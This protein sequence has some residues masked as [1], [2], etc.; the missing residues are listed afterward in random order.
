MSQ[1]VSD[2]AMAEV[3]AETRSDSSSRR[4]G[5]GDDDFVTDLPYMHRVGTPPKQPLFQEIKHSL[6][7]TFFADK[8]F[9]KFKDQSGSRKFVLALQSLFPIL[10]WGRDYNLKKFRGDFV[11]G[12]T[13]ASLCIPQDLAYAK[14][15][16]LDPWY[17]LYSSFVAPLVYAFMGTSRDI[18]IGP[19]AVVSLLLGSLLSS[20]ISD[21]KS[22]DYVR[23]AFTATFFAGVTQLVLGVCRLGFLIDFLSHAAIVGFMAGAAI[24]IALQQLK[25]LLGIKNFTTK[26]DIVSVLHSVWSNVHHGWNWETILI[27][28]SFLIFL[29]ITKYIAKRNKKLFWVSAISPMIS[30]VVSTFFVYITRAD[31]KGVSIVK[32]IKS[33]VNPSSANEIF[34]S[35]KYLGAGVRIGIVSGMVALTEAVAI[36]RTFAAMKDYS[37]DGNKEMVAMGTMNIVGSLTSCYVTTGSFSRSAVNFMAGCQTAVS[38]IVM[39]IVVLLTLLVLTPLF[40]YT[41]NAV[42]ASIIIAAVVNLVNIEAMVLLWKIDKFD[43]VACMGAFFGVIFKSVEIGLLIA[44]AISFAKIL[45]QVTRPRTAVLGKLPGTTVY[46]NIQQYPKAAQIPGM[47][48]IRIDSAIYFS[49]SNYIK[50]RILRWLIEEESQRTESELPGIQNLIVE[51]SPVTDIDTSGI[52]AF[53]ELYKTLQKREVQLILANPGPVVIEKLHASKLTDLIGEDKIFLTVADAVATFGPKDWGRYYTIRN[54]RG[55]F[56][57]GLTTASLCIPQDIAYAKLANLDPHHALYASFVT[58][59][60]YAAMG[61]SRDIAIGPAA[62]VSLLLGAMLSHDIRDH[63]SHEYLRLAFTATFFAGVTQ[64]ALGVLRLGFLIDFLS[65]AAIVGFMSGA[66]I[67][68][69]LQQLRGLL[70]IPHFTKKT[71]IISG[72]GSVNNAIVHHE[73]NL[74]TIIIG[75]SCLIFLLITKYIGKKHK[76]LFWV[77]AI[78]P[79]TCVIVSTIC[80]Y[81]TR[82]DEKGVSTINH[83]K[84]GLNSVSANEIF[85]RGKYVVRGF[86]IGAVAGI[87]ALTEAVSIGRTFAAMKHYTL[88]GNKEMVAMGTMNIVGSLTSC[89]VATGSF[90]RSAVNNMAGCETAASNIVLSIV[91]LL[92]LTLFTP[93]FKY[94]PNAVLSSIIIAATTNLVNINAVIM[95]WKIDKFDFMACMGA[96][97]GVIFMNLEYALIIAVSISFVKIV[98]RVTWPKVVVLGK[99]PG[100]S[101]YRNIEQYPKAFQITAMLILRVDSAIYFTNCNF[102]KD[103]I[104][105]WLRYENEERA[106]CELAEIQYV[107]V[108]M[109]AVSDIDSSGISSFERLYH[110]LEKL[111]VQL[112]LANVGK[113]VMEKL[114]ES[115]LTELIGR[116]KIFLSVAGAVITYG[117]KREEL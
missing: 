88:D 108:D 94:T 102:V 59:L 107:V 41:P 74:E 14:L 100:T 70:G 32:H 44:V 4:H 112:V 110:S 50:E 68:I 30:V 52:H 101:I 106:E 18:A 89:F 67:I 60:V 69:S 45:L 65:H 16:Y 66:A 90:S 20:E 21:T 64:L 11:S 115:K 105:R 42:L 22:H 95:I 25:G 24:T 98:F 71:D 55:D 97:F 76:K 31:E 96:F 26:T 56:I 29:L 43:F 99:I 54:L 51:M 114:Q 73:W 38:N 117:P 62:V 80:V 40:K 17:G 1:R 19:V 47:L 116:D 27:G 77:A 91:V 35:G 78:A 7:E 6:M 5:G 13:I 113:I 39:S 72:I 83:I 12:L 49:N 28:L 10:E 75:T 87:V 34:F 2:D 111:H 8:P 15:A 37:L 58:P 57:A 61:S 81:I 92:V 109:S 46:R 79:M 48:I 36:G 93:V 103:R 85:F 3:I 53:E 9:H 23:L 63:K 104:L 86:R 84:G 33:G 82:A